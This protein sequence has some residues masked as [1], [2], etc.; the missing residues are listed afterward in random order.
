MSWPSSLVR[1]SD[2]D[3]ASK[4]DYLD[5]AEETLEGLE[6]ALVFVQL[7]DVDSDRGSGVL[8]LNITGKPLHG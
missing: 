3:C 2:Y 7:Q 8:L 5:C 6:A 1:K 4:L